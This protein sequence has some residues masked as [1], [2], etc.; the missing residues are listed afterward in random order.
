MSSRIYRWKHYRLVGI[1]FT[2][3][4]LSLIAQLP[5]LYHA[6]QILTIQSASI[7][8]SSL[9]G[10]G[11]A[12][13]GA[14]ILFT[15]ALARRS[16][17]IESQILYPMLGGSFVSITLYLGIYMLFAF[18]LYIRKLPGLSFVHPIFQLLFLIVVTTVVLLYIA[19]KFEERTR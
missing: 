19:A 5:T 13:T 1:V 14:G 6:H 18:L 7:L 10:G 17:L 8:I 16:N 11:L 15:E 12:I 2:I 3:F 9:I 4:G